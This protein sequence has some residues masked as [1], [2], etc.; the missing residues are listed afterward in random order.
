MRE[1]QRAHATPY[2][3][4]HRGDAVC[5]KAEK[6]AVE[7]VEDGRNRTGSP[8]REN[9]SGSPNTVRGACSRSRGVGSRRREDGCWLEK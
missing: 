4:P 9:G 3:C 2:G 7:R 5:V 1:H 8:A 6:L